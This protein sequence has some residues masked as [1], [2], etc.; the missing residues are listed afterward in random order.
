MVFFVM[1][2]DPLECCTL[3]TTNVNVYGPFPHEKGHP[4]EMGRDSLLSAFFHSH[5]HAMIRDGP[6]CLGEGV[7][8]VSVRGLQLTM[9]SEHQSFLYAL[10]GC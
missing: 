2:F 8:V 4:Q 7:L 1:V 10:E 5:P 6:D 3:L 9:I